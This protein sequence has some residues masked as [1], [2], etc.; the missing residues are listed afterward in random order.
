MVAYRLHHEPG[1]LA[2][3]DTVRSGQ[4][5]A[6]AVFGFKAL[7]GLL[8]DQPSREERL[9]VWAGA[10][11]GAVSDQYRAQPFRRRAD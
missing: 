8:T 1:M 2:A 3:L 10:G 11:H 4:A 6:V 9:L 7:A 5:G